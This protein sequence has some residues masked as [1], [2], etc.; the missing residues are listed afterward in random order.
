MDADEVLTTSPFLFGYRGRDGR[1]AACD[2]RTGERFRLTSLRA[3]EIASSFLEPRS[4]SSAHEEGFTAAE[5]SQALEA[6]ILVTERESRRLEL[7]EQ[8]G[9]SRPAYLLFSQMDIPYRD[10]R[11]PVEDMEALTERRRATVEEYQ[12]ASGYRSPEPLAGGDATALPPP[13]AVAPRLSALVGRRSAR[14]FT[15]SPPSVEE[16]AGVLHGATSAFRAVAADRADGDPF[17]L[18]NSFYSWAHL[19]VVV[20]EVT[21]AVPG[22]YEYDWMRHRL[23]RAADSDDEGALLACVQGQRWILG[24]GFVVFVVAD[25][26]SYAWLYRH[27]RAYLHL[28]I[29][30]G[31]LGQ[32]LLMA[33]TALG[34]G[35]WTSP[36]I[37]ESRA[38]RLL[39]LPDDDAV[40]VLAMLK[41]GR[42]LT[43]AGQ[44]PPRGAAS[45]SSR[46][47]SRSSKVP[48]RAFAP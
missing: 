31:E 18:M 46:A 34:L 20:Q 22:V 45:S 4:V 43:P 7:W 33:A 29:Q 6:G 5:L 39:G 2:A 42:P 38:A 48:G 15:A 13:H 30:V 24:N 14:A 26:R 1:L 23:L 21:G 10:A 25:L 28:L 44:L 36:A 41:L 12:S 16:M 8:R 19:F 3:A 17:R 35:G 27:S 47:T 40:D 32:E 9:W 11:E 37:H